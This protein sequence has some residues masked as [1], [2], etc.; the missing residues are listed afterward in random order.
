MSIQEATRA[1]ALKRGEGKAVWLLNGLLTWKADAKTT[2]GAWELV[3]QLCPRGFAPPIH[4]HS[5]EAEA[6]Y[7]L[8]GD[9]TVVL[10]EEV[11]PASPGSFFYVPPD[12]KHSFVVESPVARFLSFA[13]PANLG[14]FLDELGEPAPVRALPPQPLPLDPERFDAVATKYGQKTWGPPPAP[15]R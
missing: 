9:L 5:R 15:R 11:V 1:Y 6:F 4:T 8:D 2:G 10:G 7:V 3:E 14:A 13:I 12:T